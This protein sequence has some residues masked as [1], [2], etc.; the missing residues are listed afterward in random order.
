[1]QRF[2]SNLPVFLIVAGLWAIPPMAHSQGCVPAHFMSVTGLGARGI[3]YLGPGQWQASFSYRYLNSNVVFIGNEEQPQLHRVGTRNAINAFDLTA[4]YGLSSRFNLALSLPFL[5]DNYSIINPDGMRHSGSTGGVGDLRLVAN[6][7]LFDTA[8][9]PE[10]NVLLG[11]GVKFPTGDD[12]ATGHF[13]TANG[14]ILTRPIFLSAQLGDGGYGMILQLQGFQ[15]LWESLYGYIEGDYLINPREQNDTSVYSPTINNTNSVPDSYFARAGL[16]YAIWPEGGLSL[17][18]GARI[19]GV[20]VHDLVGGSGGFRIAG[21]SVYVDPG[22]SW[23]YGRSSVSVNVPVAVERN[24][25]ATSTVK[26]GAL[27]GYLVVASYSI[28]F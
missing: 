8:E 14:V 21:Y 5:H 18:M 11:L 15:K 26:A 22:V 4:I 28:R 16:S 13:H 3:D 12:H 20:P 10:G 7:W 27:S 19:D 9:H 17:S 25:Q 23:S 6:G 2:R 24:I 1:M